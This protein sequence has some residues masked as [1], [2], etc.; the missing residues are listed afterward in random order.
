[1]RDSL[2]TMSLPEGEPI[3][4]KNL[5]A[6][7]WA[8][9]DLPRMTPEYFDKFTEI[10]G[11]DNIEWLTRAEYHDGSKRGQLF[12]SPAGMDRLKVHTTKGQN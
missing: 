10:V 3:I 12:I 2:Y 4:G 11:A 8:Y 6:E 5:R 9:R 1:M 7:G